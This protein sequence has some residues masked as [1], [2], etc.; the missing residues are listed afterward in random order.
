[1]KTKTIYLQAPLNKGD[2]WKTG[3]FWAFAFTLVELIVVITI[4]AILATI[5][6]ISYSSYLSWAR[7][8]NRVSQLASISDWLEIYRTNND[9]PQ[10]ENSV[11]V[12][13]WT[14]V[15]WYQWYMWK[16]NLETIWYSKWWID[17]KDDTYF[18]YYLTSDWK[19]FQLMAFLEDESNKQV[20][21][22]NIWVKTEAVNYNKRY[23]TVY[24]KKLGIL[25]ESWTNAPIQEV[26]SIKSAWYLNFSWSTS[27]Y[28]ANFTDK[29][30]LIWSWTGLLQIITNSSCKRIKEV[31]WNKWDW[32]YTINP[33]WVL[34]SQVYCDM[35]TDWGGWLL[36]ANWSTTW[37]YRTFPWDS[38]LSKSYIYG[39]YSNV[40][41]HN[42]NYYTSFSN[43]NFDDIL[44]ISWNKKYYCW[45]NYSELLSL[46]NSNVS[47][48]NII[49]KYSKWTIK[50]TWEQTNILWRSTLEDPWIWCAWTHTENSYTY[51]MTFWW[52]DNRIISPPWQKHSDIA[53][54]NNWIWIFIR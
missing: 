33:T 38:N 27:I 31:W 16:N 54:D 15:I 50:K 44:F 29:D 26:S 1:M 42:L 36:V 19:N 48:P 7:D 12:R 32:T 34:E 49:I 5:W 28:K 52:E 45:F 47:N 17:P 24:G 46:T 37:L 20:V 4:L 14:T 22:N 6:F 35:T 9:L 30:S 11:E 39:T 3:G 8:S 53:N 21:K 43:I 40:W 10:P 2:G 25:T 41:D 23:P 18:S 51:S 13:V